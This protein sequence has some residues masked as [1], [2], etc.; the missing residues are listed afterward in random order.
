M[1]YTKIRTDLIKSTLNLLRPKDKSYC[2]FKKGTISIEYKS[3]IIA[4]MKSPIAFFEG[5]L[6]SRL[7]IELGKIR[8]KYL[9]LGIKNYTI[10]I[11]SEHLHQS[12]LFTPIG[13]HDVGIDLWSSSVKW[14]PCRQDIVK[15]IYSVADL[16]P[17][18]S[19]STIDKEDLALSLIHMVDGYVYAFNCY[20]IRASR[21]KLSAPPPFNISLSP[22]GIKKVFSQIKK[23]KLLHVAQADIQQG[24]KVDK[25]MAF[26]FGDIRIWVPAVEVNDCNTLEGE[27]G[28]RI[29]YG[30]N[31]VVS[32]V[33]YYLSIPCEFIITIPPDLKNFIFQ[34]KVMRG[35]DNY[36]TITF[37]KNKIRLRHQIKSFSESE[38]TIFTKINIP[39][40]RIKIQVNHLDFKK[41]LINKTLMGLID[42][43]I[44]NGHC[45]LYFR[46]R[47]SEHFIR[48]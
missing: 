44:S 18:S 15:G 1:N 14:N 39:K 46:N 5:V 43:N 26:D 6:D 36:M 24:T 48:T 9:C 45:L 32:K 38:E 13:C 28:G 27:R 2:V 37:M 42:L 47:T 19:I 23:R 34:T 21:Y 11:K 41:A 33:N 31:E 7:F 29:N 40:Y 16:L 20:S 17:W 10:K 25:G 8:K 35:D 4:S 12:I 22:V 30:R 3:G